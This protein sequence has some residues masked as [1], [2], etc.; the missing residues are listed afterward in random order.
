MQ[1]QRLA[2]HFALDLIRSNLLICEHISSAIFIVE[3]EMQR[4]LHVFALS[5]PALLLAGP[6]ARGEVVNLVNETFDR[7]PLSYNYAYGYAGGGN[8]PTCLLYTSPSPRDS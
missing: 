5:I 7:A 1:S 2:I 4:S 6:V 3:E 8:P